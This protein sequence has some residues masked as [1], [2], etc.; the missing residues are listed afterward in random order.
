VKALIL[1]EFEI[2]ETVQCEQTGHAHGA[3]PHAAYILD[4]GD[5]TTFE[6][7]A[8]D[9][10]ARP[11]AVDVPAGAVAGVTADPTVPAAELNS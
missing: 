3:A 6:V 2:V 9:A 1:K 5:G 8:L 4:N 11:E 7:C 10:V